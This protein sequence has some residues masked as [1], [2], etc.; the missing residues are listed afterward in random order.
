MDFGC[1]CVRHI[2]HTEPS[3]LPLIVCVVCLA[4]LLAR[5]G[6]CAL[7]TVVQKLG[8]GSFTT[9]L[10]VF[11]AIWLVSLI[12]QL[13]VGISAILWIPI[14]YAFFFALNLR[15]QVVRHYNI[16]DNGMLGE[17]CIGFWCWY[18]SVAQSKSPAD[19]FCA[20]HLVPHCEGYEC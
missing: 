2:D 10:W 19:R 4:H 3:Q 12:L 17:C 13:V 16:T 18:C 14:I 1:D 8:L 7:S 9:T 5:G 6:N 15:M 11:C 20:S